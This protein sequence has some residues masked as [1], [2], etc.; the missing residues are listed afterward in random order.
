MVTFRDN[1]GLSA[2][3]TVNSHAFLHWYYHITIL[4][5]KWLMKCNSFQLTWNS[6]LCT[7]DAPKTIDSSTS[8]RVLRFANGFQFVDDF[9]AYL[10]IGGIC[11]PPSSTPFVLRQVEVPGAPPV[12]FKLMLWNWSFSHG[13][14]L[15]Q[16]TLTGTFDIVVPLMLMKRTSLIFTLD[17]IICK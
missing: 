11:I 17:G 8:P 16:T 1:C 6:S 4:M 13:N 3:I 12:Y 2:S 5:H 15:L 14:C 10:Q 7:K 9:W